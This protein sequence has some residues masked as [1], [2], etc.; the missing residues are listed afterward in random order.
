MSCKNDLFGNSWRLLLVN[1]HIDHGFIPQMQYV[2][3]YESLQGWI[4]RVDC[5]IYFL[6]CNE[7]S[8][9]F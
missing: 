8:M 6:I 2:K 3:T 4:S 9:G 7:I 5:V 1:L